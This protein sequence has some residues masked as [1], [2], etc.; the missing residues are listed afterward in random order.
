MLADWKSKIT[1]SASDAYGTGEMQ[2][3]SIGCPKSA[4]SNTC[5]GDFSVIFSGIGDVATGTRIQ[6]VFIVEA[7]EEPFIT[8]TL[9]G[10]LDSQSLTTV[11]NGGQVP[12]GS[13]FAYSI[14]PADSASRDVEF[15]RLRP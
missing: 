11:A 6:L 12:R 15:Y 10:P 1:P 5:E 7:D 13:R 14:L 4:N 3:F 2:L 8:K 9:S